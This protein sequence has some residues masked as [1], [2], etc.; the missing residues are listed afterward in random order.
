MQVLWIA[1]RRDRAS[2]TVRVGDPAAIRAD[3]SGACGRPSTRPLRPLGLL[4]FR[5]GALNELQYRVNFCRP[6]LPVAI[7]LGTG[8]AV[9]AS[10]SPDDRARTAGRS[11]SC[12]PSSVSTSCMGGLIRTFIQ[13]N[14]ERLMQDVRQGTLD[15]VLTKPEDAQVLVSVREFRIWQSV[16]VFVGADRAR[17]RG[18]ANSGASVG[19]GRGSAVRLRTAARRR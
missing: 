16:D 12:S 14:M 5:V 4:F 6:A 2:S 15:Y 11:R 9:L 13:P 8:L 19:F 3:S 17:D 10:S 7:A 18:R 1:H